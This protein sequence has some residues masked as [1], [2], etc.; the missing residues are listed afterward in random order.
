MVMRF[1]KVI[2]HGTSLAV[3]IPAPICRE[4]EIHRGDSLLLEVVLRPEEVA[5]L[6]LIYLQIS[7]VVD[8]HLPVKVRTND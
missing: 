6:A 3:V 8:D 7:S 4:L 1:Q 5:G 2:Q